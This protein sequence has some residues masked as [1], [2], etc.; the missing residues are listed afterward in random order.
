MRTPQEKDNRYEVIKILDNI[1]NLNPQDLKIIKQLAK[2]GYNDK[3][4]LKNKIK[5]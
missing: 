5:K 3:I 4:N 2:K 1:S